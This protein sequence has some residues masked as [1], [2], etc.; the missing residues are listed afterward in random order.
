MILSGIFARSALV[1]GFTATGVVE[2]PAGIGFLTQSEPPVATLRIGLEVIA[3]E[4][5]PVRVVN[6]SQAPAAIQVNRIQRFMFSKKGS[7]MMNGL[8]L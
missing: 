8:Q 1:I 2:L 4:G 5:V 7:A 3:A 6:A